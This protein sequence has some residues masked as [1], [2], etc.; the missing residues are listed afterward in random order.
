[1]NDFILIGYR[2]QEGATPPDYLA[3]HRIDLIEAVE[4]GLS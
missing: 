4:M 2:L 1:M 3:R